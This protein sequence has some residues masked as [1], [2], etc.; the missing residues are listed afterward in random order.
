M[1]VLVGLG[2][3]ALVPVA[4]A[5]A[6]EAALAGLAVVL[7]SL[8]LATDA[9]PAASVVPVA[10]EP[11]ARAN[12]VLQE[13]VAAAALAVHHGPVKSCRHSSRRD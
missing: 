1:A 13:G 6:V 4:V 2:L 10:Q 12:L 11:A 9:G 8:G 5:A 7:V 3:A